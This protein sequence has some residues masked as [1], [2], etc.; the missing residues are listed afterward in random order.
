MDCDGE[1]WGMTQQRVGTRL[2][3]HLGDIELLQK[4][5]EECRI[6]KPY[7]FK[8]EIE[9]FLEIELK[10]ESNKQEDQIVATAEK[11]K[12]TRKKKSDETRLDKIKKLAKQ[13]EKSGLVNHHACT[14]HRISDYKNTDFRFFG[15]RSQIPKK[16]VGTRSVFGIE[17]EVKVIIFFIQF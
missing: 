3:Q 17:G 15:N 8:K 6:D 4:L 10:K 1:Y 5:R 11:T 16:S 7:D 12:R 9:D 13:Y 2:N 14:G